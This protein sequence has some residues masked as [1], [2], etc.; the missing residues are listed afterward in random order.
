[1]EATAKTTTQRR[2]AGSKKL[3]VDADKKYIVSRAINISVSPEGK[4][5]AYN[6]LSRP[7]KEINLDLMLI[8]NTFLVPSTP[9]E[10]YAALKEIFSISRAELK[11][12]MTQLLNNNI[13][14]IEQ[15]APEEIAS[16]T[17]AFAS[18]AVHHY[19]LRD[20]VRV[21]AYKTAIAASVKGKRVIDLGCGTGILS[22]FAAKAG[23]AHVTAI[24]ES[25]I[26]AVA[27]EMFR[28]NKADQVIT[29]YKSNSKDVNIAERADILIH[30]IIGMDPLDENILIYIADAK[31]RFLKSGGRLIPGRME[32]CCIGY[33]DDLSGYFVNEA[34]AFE[35]LYG[36]SFETYIKSLRNA[37]AEKLRNTVNLGNKEF[38]GRKALSEEA[39]LYD[40][41]FNSDFSEET[42]RK[43]KIKLKP[44]RDGILGGALIYF[45]AHLTDEVV[46]STS[47]YAAPTHWRQ[48]DIPFNAPRKVSTGADVELSFEIKNVNGKQAIALELL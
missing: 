16:A 13:L 9:E 21:M 23:A 17:S 5:M 27:E 25:S 6:S 45:R 40:I 36:L 26:A 30:E 42:R 47:P 24:E 15:S 32:I 34:A 19:M 35:G 31:K 44:I 12:I 2:S 20:T 39:V 22:L 7:L 33:E 4:L 41:D 1:M 14:T 28:D 29:L 48:K 37:P 11:T 3:K 8:L 10:A 43:K 46:L 18:V 38:S